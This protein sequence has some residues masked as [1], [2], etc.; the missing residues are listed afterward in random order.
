MAYLPSFKPIPFGITGLRTNQPSP[1]TL[2]GKDLTVPGRQCDRFPPFPHL[3]TLASR[4]LFCSSSGD[5]FSLGRD[6]ASGLTMPKLVS[7]RH[8]LVPIG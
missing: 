2:H 3:G 4:E 8:G 1:C 6:P 5:D 7:F